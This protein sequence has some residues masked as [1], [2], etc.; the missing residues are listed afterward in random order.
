MLC[1]ETLL[2][3]RSQVHSLLA[4]SNTSFL[5]PLFGLVVPFGWHP[6]G[7]E[8]SFQVNTSTSALPLVPL[9]SCFL[10]L[11]RHQTSNRPPQEC[12]PKK[13]IQSLVLWYQGKTQTYSSWPWF[14][15]ER[16]PLSVVTHHLLL[17]QWD[18]VTGLFLQ[19]WGGWTGSYSL[20]HLLAES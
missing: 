14:Q 13:E 2:W 8:P 17:N 10:P 12:K 5:L 20:L 16:I 15:E 11:P 4:A 3:E 1:R 6:P 7:S 9:S 19:W 18:S